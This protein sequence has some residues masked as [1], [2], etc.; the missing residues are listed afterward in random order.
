MYKILVTDSISDLGLKKLYEH[1]NFLV[2]K[3]NDLTEQELLKII[4]NYDALVVR[5]QT[6]VTKKLIE[7]A[8]RLQIIARA[9]VGVDNIDI[10]AATRKGII[11][12]NAPGANTIA[13]T[14]H[15][16]AMLLSLARKIPHA[17]QSTSNGEWKRGA[18]KGVE[19]YEKTL[20]I[21]GMGKIGT[22]VA[23]RAKSF[24][25]KI[26]GFDPYL[27][28]ER[29]KKL[30]ITKASLEEIAS[31]SDFITFHTPLTNETRGLVNEE[32]INKMK[33]GVRLVN[34][35][36]GGIINEAALLQGIQNGV[37]AGAALDVFEQEP[38]TNLELLQHPNIIATPHLG[39]STEEAQE[40]VAIEVSEEIISIFESNSIRHAINMPQITGE[41]HQKM[42]PFLQLG[43]Q[44]AALA[45]QLFKQA[46]EKIEISYAGELLEEDT[47]L[48]TRTMI[49]GILSYHL[50]DT[51]NIINA[52]HLLKEHGLTYNVQRNAANK[53][54][55]NYMELNL[56]A[57]DHLVK[58]G[59]TVLNGYGERIVKINNYQVDVKP[60]QHLLYIKHNDIPG[61]IGLVGS[62]LG[63]YQINIGTMQ[64]GR[65]TIGGEAIMVLTLDKKAEKEVVQT[66]KSLKGIE[67]VEILE[68]SNGYAFKEEET[69]NS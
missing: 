27:T 34:C 58:I 40:K 6:I 62:I 4:E 11:V 26:L 12:I 32:Y 23:K 38:P 56:S 3:K 8:T 59:A 29:A 22:E 17:H 47:S 18:F 67:D 49:K 68:L 48:L 61:M 13:A 20:G 25:M 14:E 63:N 16:L 46:P 30:G 33:K 10:E 5:S 31:E 39:A 37:I 42:K 7:H 41:A 35:A 66:L 1:P 44:V 45:I 65:A 24:Q 53:G 21:V 19:L 57:G 2:D 36:R 51:V 69:I 50:S 52:M 55:S 60:E 43:E 9:G 64:V 15:T 54:F 28:E